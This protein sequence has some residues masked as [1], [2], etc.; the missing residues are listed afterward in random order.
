MIAYELH[1]SK[2]QLTRRLKSITGLTPMKYI[3]L[4]KLQKA[5]MML[6]TEEVLTLKEVC[7]SVGFENTTHFAKLFEKEFG[8]RPHEYLMTI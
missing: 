3:R 5:K 4:V 6:E 2:S 8:K 7:Y 1:M